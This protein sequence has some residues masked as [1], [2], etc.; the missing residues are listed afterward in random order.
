MQQ[1]VTLVGQVHVDAVG[2]QIIRY[3]QLIVAMVAHLLHDL[4]TRDRN[5]TLRTPDNKVVQPV[6][7]HRGFRRETE[8]IAVSQTIRHFE[9]EAKATIPKATPHLSPG[10]TALEAWGA[11]MENTGDRQTFLLCRCHDIDVI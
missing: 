3:H 4:E 7:V 8:K 5:E 6:R 1:H 2:S 9:T 10:Q 11:L